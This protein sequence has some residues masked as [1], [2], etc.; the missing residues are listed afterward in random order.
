MSYTLPNVSFPYYQFNISGMSLTHSF[1]GGQGERPDYFSGLTHTRYVDKANTAV[2]NLTYVPTGN[3]DPNKI[4]KALADSGGKC[5]YQYGVAGYRSKTY[6]GLIY[7]YKPSFSEGVLS[8]SLSIVSEAVT[9]N[10]INIQDESLCVKPLDQ[11]VVYETIQE[12]VTSYVVNGVTYSTKEEAEKAAL[13]YN[14]NYLATVNNNTF[15]VPGY[16]TD[17][18]SVV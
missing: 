3:D 17:R 4:E 11:R 8:Y 16:G 18:K 14:Y 6:R 10:F 7:D 15:N 12:Q 9:Y 13:Q 2:I 1:K 5:T